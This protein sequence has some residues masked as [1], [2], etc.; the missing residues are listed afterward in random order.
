[1]KVMNSV[2]RRRLWVPTERELTG[3]NMPGMCERDLLRDPEKG[4]IWLIP[5]LRS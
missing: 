3:K 2:K 5:S 1:M 4:L